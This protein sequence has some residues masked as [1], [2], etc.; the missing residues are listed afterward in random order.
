MPLPCVGI[1]VSPSSSVYEVLHVGDSSVSSPANVRPVCGS[2]KPIGSE[3]TARDVIAGRLI[4]VEACPLDG[5][6]SLKVTNSV[7]RSD[8]KA[9]TPV[10]QLFPIEGSPELRPMYSTE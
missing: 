8:W 4:H 6:A 3:S 10:F 5:Q 1:Q 7:C 2:V 9:V